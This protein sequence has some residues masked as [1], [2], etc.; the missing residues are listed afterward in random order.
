MRQ[1][2]L[3]FFFCFLISHDLFARNL[4]PNPGFESYS[5]CPKGLGE[6]NRLEEW[7]SPNG[8]TPDFFSACYTKNFETVGVPNNYFGI[9]PSFQGQAYVGIYAGEKETEYLQVRL[10]EPLIAGETYCLRFFASPPS[11]KAEQLPSLQAWFRETMMNEKGW[12]EIDDEGKAM[13]LSYEMST[14]VAEWSLMS[15]TF[16]ATG[17][18]RYLIL[19]YFAPRDGRGYTYLDNFGLYEYA[20][21]EGCSSNYFTGES[22]Q[23]MENFVPNPGFEISYGCPGAREE[24]QYC[25]GWRVMENTPD[26]FHECGT[27]TASVPNNGLGYQKPHDGRAYGGFWCYLP[28]NGDYREFISM[29]LQWPLEKGEVYCLS[30][31]VSLSDLSQAALYDMQM[32]PSRSIKGIPSSLPSD[33]P[34]VVKLTDGDRLLNDREGWTK[35][36]ALFVAN[37]GE[38]VLTIGNFRKNHDPKIVIEDIELEPK[39]QYGVSSYYYV[40]DV[41]L[42]RKDAGIADC[43]PG[44]VTQIVADPDNPLIFAGKLPAPDPVVEDTVSV[45]EWQAGDTLTLEHFLFAFD[46]AELESEALPLL[47]TLA[48]YLERHPELIIE[49]TGHT[50]DKG[51]EAYN[52][53]LSEN[54]A[55][56][57]SGYIETKGIA[58][59]RIHS[60]GVGETE[61]L[62]P[63]DDEGS[64]TRNRRVEIRFLEE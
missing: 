5:R 22:N 18:E 36:N 58:G 23:D 41:V 42:C 44:L 33:D 30:M 3:V 62:T 49:I 1:V 34:R 48:A 26:F 53:K 29:E 2:F 16:E 11:E 13:P 39:K 31:W 38:R 63:N 43:S 7:T 59:S 12:E 37:G 9:Q 60:N 64:R 15:L 6:L 50:D 10:L 57:V 45:V 32:L 47:D 14:G 8:G 52:L 17:N 40:D 35:V 21:P 24:M 4:I 28:K 46:A 56:T 25:Y 54:R 20:S 27:G 51:T 55:A 19:G 61:P